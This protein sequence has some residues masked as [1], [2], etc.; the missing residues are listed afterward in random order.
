VNGLAIKN[1][2]LTYDDVKE[3]DGKTYTGMRVGGSHSWNYNNGTWNEIKV[4]PDKWK[5]EFSCVKKR[6]HQAPIG[7]GAPIRTEYHWYILAD[8]KVVKLDDN[9]YDTLM[10]GVKF[11]IGY[12]RP[13]WNTW[14]YNY[15][16]E[17]PE[18]KIIAILED[19]IQ[20]LKARKKKKEL[21]KFM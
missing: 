9:S 12:K 2:K 3:H 8:Q 20:R 10:K 11:K 19:Y 1:K 17:S 14:S 16:Q 13:N 15:K 18:D 5:I 21:L 6:K 4:T 7:S